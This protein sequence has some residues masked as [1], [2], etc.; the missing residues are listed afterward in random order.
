MC[1]LVVT[2]MMS[3]YCRSGYHLQEVENV[4]CVWL[5]GHNRQTKCLLK[6]APSILMEGG[7]VLFGCDYDH[8]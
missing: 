8:V 3:E 4:V 1:C 2:G 6:S 5:G 7:K